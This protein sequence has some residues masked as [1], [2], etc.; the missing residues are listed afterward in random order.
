MKTL[1]KVGLLFTVPVSLI[2][3]CKEDEI[4][5]PDDLV[6]IP[7]EAFL[8]ALIN[9]GVDTNGDGLINYDEA[10]AVS[11]LD[12]YEKHISDMTGIEFFPNLLHLN[13]YGNQIASL[14]VSN[15]T[16][17]TY[18]DCSHN[19]LSNLDL[20]SNAALRTL[21][22]MLNQLTALDVSNNTALGGLNCWSNQLTELNVLNNT[23]LEWLNCKP[24]A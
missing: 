8:H 11:H 10:K 23:S 20:S 12:V 14:D 15:N 2:T 24:S 18:L 21:E 6:D 9:E 4:P 7:N 3:Q 16:A 1:I 17:L 19:Q 13:C 5:I 22:C